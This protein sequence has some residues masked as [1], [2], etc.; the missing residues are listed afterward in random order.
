[1]AQER[2]TQVLQIGM[3]SCLSRSE[4]GFFQWEAEVK[5]EI[6]IES[7]SSSSKLT[8]SPSIIPFFFTRHLSRSRRTFGLAR[9]LQSHSNRER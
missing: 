3:M 7:S 9:R 4:A 8:L 1:M 6:E 2:K 5:V